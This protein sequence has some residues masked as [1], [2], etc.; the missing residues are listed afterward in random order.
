MRRADERSDPLRD[1]MGIDR[2][3]ENAV[4]SGGFDLLLGLARRRGRKEE[5][6]NLAGGWILPELP[7]DLQ[8]IHAGHGDVEEDEVGTEPVRGLE[9]R[10]PVIRLDDRVSQVL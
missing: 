8:A 7:A 2:L 6:G 5:D 4:A 10:F 1:Q 9:R 3:E